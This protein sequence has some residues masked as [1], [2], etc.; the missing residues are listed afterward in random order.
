VSSTVYVFI[1]KGVC[2]Q[3][4]AAL[5]FSIF[6]IREFAQFKIEHILVEEF[7]AFYKCWQIAM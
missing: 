3:V 6:R 5:Y 2:D 4:S 7:S 1:F